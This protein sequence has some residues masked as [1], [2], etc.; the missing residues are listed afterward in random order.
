MKLTK[1]L[2][3]NLISVLLV[4]LVLGGCGEA[5]QG[6]GE[7]LKPAD[8]SDAVT[9]DKDLVT[10]DWYI[11][12]SW[13]N[14]KWGQ[15]AVSKA[16]TEKTGVN[17]NF[18]TP[19]GNEEEKLN[20]LI[21]SGS[22]PDLITLG[23][24]EPQVNEIIRSQCDEKGLTYLARSDVGAEERYIG[25][26]LKLKQVLINILGNA[27]KFTPVPGS[28]T[29]TTEKTAA[30]DD[31]QTL[32]F[33]VKD[34][35]IGMGK[36]YLAHIFEPFSQEDGTRT[37]RYGGSGLGLSITKSIVDM[38][39][40][41]IRAES[42]KGVGTTFTVIVTLKRA[43][44]AAPAARAPETADG[45]AAL[46]GRRVLIAEDMELNAEILTELLELEDMAADRAENGQLALELFSGS[47]P[48]TYDAILMDMRMP[49][50]DGLAAARAIRALDRPDAK[51]IPI[52]ALTANAFEEDVQSVLQ[53]GMNA[54]LSKPVDTDKLFAL[55]R[56]L[57]SS[58]PTGAADA[59]KGG[60]E[61]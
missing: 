4:S 11:N 58:A 32:R 19:Q 42:E 33:T 23:W 41:E 38:M 54:H 46:A 50:M 47:P 52:I 18:I 39:N 6:N 15:N 22:L 53:A 51:T 7:T 30:Y 34:T 9:T 31:R 14:T 13:F 57:I 28:V 40:G 35:G 16:I 25:D 10:F 21:A 44:S 37:S 48:G 2:K 29:F 3:T 20:A 59:Q 24:W 49:V 43:E 45:A 5:H 1:L 56:E 27:V 60:S 8:T 55:L 36:D 12:Y 61:C 26:A 17:I